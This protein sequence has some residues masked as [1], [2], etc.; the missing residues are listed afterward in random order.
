[1]CVL[2][3]PAPA[4][5]HTAPPPMPY[6][7]TQLPESCNEYHG[8][9]TNLH[10]WM[11]CLGHL[12]KKHCN[13]KNIVTIVVALLKFCAIFDCVSLKAEVWTYPDL[14]G[15]SK[16]LKSRIGYLAFQFGQVVTTTVYS[17]EPH[18]RKQPTKP[19]HPQ[20][21]Y[22]L[23]PQMLR[24]DC[25]SRAFSIYHGFNNIIFAYVALSENS[26]LADRPFK[27]AMK[28]YEF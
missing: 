14:S 16:R 1:M 22:T 13:R 26:V 11:D 2:A 10:K 28:C 23:S 21:T 6:N 8:L 18:K 27:I 5:I 7:S 9:S 20:H 3:K 4:S 15:W 19:A 17:V 25:T 24:A 12:F